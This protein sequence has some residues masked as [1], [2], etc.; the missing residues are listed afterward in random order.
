MVPR[1]TVVVYMYGYFANVH[2]A[3]Y[4]PPNYQHMDSGVMFEYFIIAGKYV[5]SIQYVHLD[6]SFGVICDI[7]DKFM[8][9]AMKYSQIG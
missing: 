1:S 7:S 4:N 8:E 6:Q 3:V 9:A 2:V 5:C